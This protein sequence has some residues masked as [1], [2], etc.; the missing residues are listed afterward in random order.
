MFMVVLSDKLFFLKDSFYSTD[1]V[2]WKIYNWIQGFI[3][4][5]HNLWQKYIHIYM[6]SIDPKLIQ[7]KILLTIVY[8][9]HSSKCGRQK[10]RRTTKALDSILDQRFVY[11]LNISHYANALLWI[12]CPENALCDGPVLDFPW[13]S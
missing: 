10:R 5:W 13:E 8:W 3:A 9:L 11:R 12:F 2:R 1:T 6:N 4:K 7:N